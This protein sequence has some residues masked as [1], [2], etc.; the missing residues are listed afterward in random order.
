MHAAIVFRI[1][2]ILSEPILVIQDRYAGHNVACNIKVR[3]R[4][5]VVKGHNRA[6]KHCTANIHGNGHLGAEGS[7]YQTTASV[8]AI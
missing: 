1:Q 6:S 4:A 3:F 8:M 2:I 7:M 5:E